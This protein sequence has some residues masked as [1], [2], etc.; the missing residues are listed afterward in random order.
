MK[1]ILLCLRVPLGVVLFFAGLFLPPYIGHEVLP[2]GWESGP[3]FWWS[4]PMAMTLLILF[5]VLVG[6]GLLLLIR[7]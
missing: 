6:S 3:L 5:A 4:L 7:K 1:T 2:E